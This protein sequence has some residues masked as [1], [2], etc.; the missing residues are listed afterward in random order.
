MPKGLPL[1]LF[2]NED[3]LELVYTSEFSLKSTECNKEVLNV[4]FSEM[5][6]LRIKVV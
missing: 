5:F 1:C 6:P 3:S 2:Q 4:Q